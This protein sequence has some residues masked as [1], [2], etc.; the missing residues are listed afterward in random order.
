MATL[1]VTHTENIVLDGRQQG[2]TQT[3]RFPNIV[4]VYSRSFKIK[5]NTLTAIYNTV[6]SDIDGGAAF[7]DGSIKYVRITNRGTEPL[8]V[9][10]IGETA[11]L[12]Y[13]YEIQPGQSYFLYNHHNCHFS[14]DGNAITTTEMRS[15]L[16]D[17][18]RVSACCVKASCKVE[19]FVASTESG[20]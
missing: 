12:N 6:D 3:M 16:E 7:D 1:T 13:V 10:V 9:N 20:T 5:A 18:D 11:A 8:V 4:D 2:S 14:D 17:I 15:S 19:V